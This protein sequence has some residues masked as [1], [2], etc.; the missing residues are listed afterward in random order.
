MIVIRCDNVSRYWADRT[1]GAKRDGSAWRGTSCGY[2]QR[3]AYYVPLLAS[4]Q[5]ISFITHPWRVRVYT[6]CIL[7]VQNFPYASDWLGV[8]TH[9]VL[10]Q[11]G[12][13]NVFPTNQGIT[14]LS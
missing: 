1:G 2:V 13:L 10:T 14:P 3:L 12:R 7:L 8:C 11:I 9:R 4:F 5:T 6:A